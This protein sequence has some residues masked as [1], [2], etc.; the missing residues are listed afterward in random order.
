MATVTADTTPDGIRSHRG[1]SPAALGIVYLVLFVGSLVVTRI[2]TGGARFPNPYQSI[3]AAQA[4]YTQYAEAVRIAA[5][6][7][8]GSAIPLG[9]FAAAMTSR[10]TYLGIRAAGVSIAL[11]GGFCASVTLMFSALLSWVQSQPGIADQVAAMRVVQLLGFAAGGVGH[12]VTLGLLLAGVCVPAGFA[13]LLPRWLVWFGLILAVICELSSL[14][15]ILPQ[16]SGLLPLGR[17]P[18]F[19]WLIGAGFTLPAAR[20]AGGAQVTDAAS[21]H[22]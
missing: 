4:Y 12:V 5:F 20:G 8:F 9:I 6:L 16:L 14:S 18:A 21:T 19:I 15:I 11:Y 2:M 22:P 1:P 7:Q 3:A 13:R 10:L 17:F